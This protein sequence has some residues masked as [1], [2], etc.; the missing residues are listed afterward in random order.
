MTFFYHSYLTF[1]HF[2]S[3]TNETRHIK[4]QETCKCK[5]RL[6]ASVCNNKQIWNNDKCR[7]QCKKLIAKGVCD[8]IFI[9]NPNTCDWECDKCWK[10]FRL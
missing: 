10:I 3:I 2:M 9:W 4:W 1:C 6:H 5:S 7:C 8:K